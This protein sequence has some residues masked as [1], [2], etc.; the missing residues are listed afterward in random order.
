MKRFSVTVNDEVLLGIEDFA[1]RRQWS[2]DKAAAELL[3]RAVRAEQLKQAR[4]ERE[5]QA[6]LDPDNP[7][8]SF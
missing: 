4:R 8:T 2:R 6:L 5:I 1:R 3:H 7:Q